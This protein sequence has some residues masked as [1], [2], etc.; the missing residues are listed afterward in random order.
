MENLVNGTEYTFQIRAVAGTPKQALQGE[1]SDTVKATPQLAVPDAP[2]NLTAT[3][4]DR[5]VS[6]SWDLPTNA[7]EIDKVQVRHQARGETTWETW[8]DLAADATEHTVTNLK[9]G[10]DYLFEVRA[11]NKAGAGPAA[12]VVGTPKLVIPDA[13]DNLTATA[14]DRSVS[15]SW[16]LPTNASVLDKVQVRHQARGETTWEPWTDLAADVTTH[17]VTNLNNGQ[18]YLFEVRAESASGAGPAART[19]ARPELAVPGKPTEFSATAGDTEVA[20]SWKLPTNT[21][22]I[23]TV[24]VRWKATADLPFDDARDKLDRPAVLRRHR[25][26]RHRPDQRHRLHLRSA[27]HQQGRQR[28]ASLRCGDAAGAAAGDAGR[29]N[30]AEHG[31]GQYRGGGAVDLADEHQSD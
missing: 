8:T 5:S 22:E 16:D 28:R 13:P 23:V 19:A 3:A 30:Q 1:P 26:H 27:R 31:A 11:E 6:L 17:T 18:D 10:Q 9:N 4:G 7:S 14:G 24:Q 25:L 29:A 2:G 15:L 21:S 20:L 12:R